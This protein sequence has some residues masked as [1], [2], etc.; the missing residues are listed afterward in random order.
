MTKAAVAAGLPAIERP[1]P[2][3]EAVTRACVF[4]RMRLRG[5]A[6]RCGSPTAPADQEALTPRRGSFTAA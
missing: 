5:L 6:M 2:I 1:M 4:A 3:G